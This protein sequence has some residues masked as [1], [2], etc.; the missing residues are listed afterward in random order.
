MSANRRFFEASM[1]SILRFCDVVVDAVKA[2]LESGGAY[3]YLRK[4][5]E[6]LLE[7]VHMVCIR[8]RQKG[9]ASPQRLSAPPQTNDTFLSVARP[10]PALDFRK[11]AASKLIMQRIG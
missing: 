5:L 1:L 4:L 6:L 10:K 11:N 9:T 3:S 8:Q 7:T 2:Q